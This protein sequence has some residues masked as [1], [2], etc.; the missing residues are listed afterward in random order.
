M[1]IFD[2]T[3][4]VIYN[5]YLSPEEEAQILVCFTDRDYFLVFPFYRVSFYN[6]EDLEQYVY[7]RTVCIHDDYTYWVRPNTF[8]ELVDLIKNDPITYRCRVVKLDSEELI[9]RFKLQTYEHYGYPD[10]ETR[11][12][13]I[14]EELSENDYICNVQLKIKE[15]ISKNNI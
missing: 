7:E 14:T 11:A 13:I 5:F 10:M 9:T 6:N 12:L 3:E 4:K 1:L 8:D 15:T 2:D